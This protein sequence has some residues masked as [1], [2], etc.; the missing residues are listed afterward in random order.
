M[1]WEK[2]PSHTGSHEKPASCH[3]VV[4][5]PAVANPQGQKIAKLMTRVLAEGLSLEHV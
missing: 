4:A 1:V 5:P 3:V 2:F